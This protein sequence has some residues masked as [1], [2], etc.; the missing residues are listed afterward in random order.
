MSLCVFN[1]VKSLNRVSPFFFYLIGTPSHSARKNRG[2]PSNNSFEVSSKSYKSIFAYRNSMYI[3][4]ISYLGLSKFL[5]SD[6][7]LL[8]HHHS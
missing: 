1:W 2:I 4:D 7:V 3:P 6:G 5:V 8:G